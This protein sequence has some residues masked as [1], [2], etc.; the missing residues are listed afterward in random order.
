MTAGQAGRAAPDWPPPGGLPPATARTSA[1]AATMDCLL[2]KY[3]ERAG[4]L[5]A[6]CRAAGLAEHCMAGGRRAGGSASPHISQRKAVQ[7]ASH[8]AGRT[9]TGRAAARATSIDAMLQLRGNICVTAG[10][11]A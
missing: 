8:A 11:N 9:C 2:W 1:A 6:S 5:E 7:H 3:M 4:A 10:G